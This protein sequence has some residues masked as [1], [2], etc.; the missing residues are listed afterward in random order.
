VNVQKSNYVSGIGAGQMLSFHPR[1]EAEP[2]AVHNA[3]I[4]TSF[5]P[6]DNLSVLFQTLASCNQHVLIF[7]FFQ[8]FQVAPGL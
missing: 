1:H 2:P 8:H 5:N 6:N 7:R 4:G 3:S